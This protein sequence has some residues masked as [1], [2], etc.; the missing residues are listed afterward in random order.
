MHS[1]FR[2]GLGAAFGMAI[3]GILRVRAKDG[4]LKGWGTGTGG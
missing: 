4:I 1:L 2:F 3:E